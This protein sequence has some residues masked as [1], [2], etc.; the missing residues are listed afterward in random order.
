TLE[1]LKQVVERTAA[2]QIPQDVQYG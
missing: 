1:A 2:A